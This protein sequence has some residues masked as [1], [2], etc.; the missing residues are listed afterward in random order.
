MIA[1][2]TNWE[3]STDLIRN[4]RILII[5]IKN[6]G[7]AAS[8]STEVVIEFTEE[9]DVKVVKHEVVYYDRKMM[10]IRIP[11][12]KSERKENVMLMVQGEIRK[13]NMTIRFEGKENVEFCGE[14]MIYRPNPRNNLMNILV[15]SI[16]CIASMILMLVVYS[17]C[18]KKKEIKFVELAEMQEYKDC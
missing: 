3:L 4:G 8:N 7:I 11:Y 6:S 1:N 14:V 16:V 2:K 18:T 5:E 15:V 12:I 17:Y 9:V 13:V 10:K